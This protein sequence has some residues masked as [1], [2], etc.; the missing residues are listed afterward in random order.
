MNPTE[1]LYR[2]TPYRYFVAHLGPNRAQRR[3]A[4]HRDSKGKLQT[5]PADNAPYTRP[6]EETDA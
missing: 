1:F 6:T 2:H 4:A 5:L 3:A